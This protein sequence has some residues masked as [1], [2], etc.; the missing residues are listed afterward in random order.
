MF[1]NRLE[2]AKTEEFEILQFDLKGIVTT[3]VSA[4]RQMSKCLCQL[5]PGDFRTRDYS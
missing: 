1:G 2:L 4:H 5:E 3:T